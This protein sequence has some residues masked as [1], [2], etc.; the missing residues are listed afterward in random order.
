M[1]RLARTQYGLLNAKAPGSGSGGKLIVARLARDSLTIRHQCDLEVP[2]GP[3]YQVS[4]VAESRNQ[5]VALIEQ[6]HQPIRLF[7]LAHFASGVPLIRKEQEHTKP[8]KQTIITRSKMRMPH[9]SSKAKWRIFH[10]AA[11]KTSAQMP[12]FRT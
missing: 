10:A 5:T 7:G 4:S 6:H 11:P 12:M 3:R 8:N 1:E 9:K 2:A